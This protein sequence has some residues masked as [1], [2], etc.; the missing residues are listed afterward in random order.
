MF[1]K[2]MLHWSALAEAL[3]HHECDHYVQMFKKK[4]QQ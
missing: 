4:N 3:Q 1:S 2:G